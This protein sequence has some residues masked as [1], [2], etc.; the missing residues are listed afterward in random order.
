MFSTQSGTE[1]HPD[2]NPLYS[3]GEKSVEMEPKL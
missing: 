1:I 2:N 3:A